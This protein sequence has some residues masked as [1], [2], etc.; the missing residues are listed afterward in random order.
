MTWLAQLSEGQRQ[1]EVVKYDLTTSG[2]KKFA[3][4]ASGCT[5]RSRRSGRNLATT[6]AARQRNVHRD[7][8]RQDTVRRD[9]ARQGT[10]RRDAARQGTVRLDATASATAPGRSCHGILRLDE[11]CQGICLL[12]AECQGI[13]LLDAAATAPRVQT[14]LSRRLRSDAAAMAYA[15]WTMSVWAFAFW[16]QRVSSGRRMSWQIASGRRLSRR[17]ASRRSCQ[18]D[19]VRT[20]LPWHM[21]SGR[22]VSGHLPSGRSA[23]LPDAE[24]HGK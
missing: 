12:D 4:T 14:Q 22:G 9:A 16:T 8:A 17:H 15:F 18:G 11:E 24:C 21:P 20:Q 6:D 3:S 5:R 13:C 7:A 1:R 23:C 10:V 19:C 2:K